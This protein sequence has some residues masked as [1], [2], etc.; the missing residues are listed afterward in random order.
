MTD[1]LENTSA[2]EEISLSISEI[3]ELIPHRYPMLLVDRIE[4]MVPGER[5]VGIKNLTMNE[6]F[7]QGHFPQRPVMPGVLTIE[8]MAQTAAAMAAYTMKSESVGK[9]VFFM[10]IDEA[11]FRKPMGPGDTIELHVQK[12][13]ARGAIWRF[14]GKA[15]VRGQLC[16]E[17]SFSAMLADPKV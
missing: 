6:A 16:C 2:V 14:T 4:R 5:A 15:L 3:M 9:I 13:K 12:E 17:S 11:K 10:S 7:F 1:T 8:A